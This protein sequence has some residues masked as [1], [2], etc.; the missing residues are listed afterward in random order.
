[1]IELEKEMTTIPCPRCGS[2][3]Y[4]RGCYACSNNSCMFRWNTEDFNEV[5]SAMDLINSIKSVEILEGLS[6]KVRNG[7][8]I[9][10][11]DAIAVVEYQKMLKKRI[12]LP[13]RIKSSIVK[14]LKR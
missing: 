14:F 3:L 7:I 13:T 2:I 6:N 10:L 11:M 4:T 5:K 8:P 9:D 12:K 1:M